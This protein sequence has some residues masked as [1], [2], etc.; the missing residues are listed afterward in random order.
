M[1][2][3]AG[4][5]RMAE[6]DDKF[7]VL[8]E[9]GRLVSSSL[10]LGEVLERVMDSLIRVTGAERGFVMLAE[11]GSGELRVEVARN[12]DHATIDSPLFAVSRNLVGEVVTQ[13]TPLLVRDALTDPGYQSFQSVVSLRLRSILCA[14]LQVRGQTIGAMYVDSRLR[15]GLFTQADLDLLVAFA[16]Q[17]AIAIENARLYRGLAQR[18]EEIAELQ[19][20]QANVFQS[21]ASGVVV[22]DAADRVTTFNAAAEAIFGVPADR[23]IGQLYPAALGPDMSQFLRAYRAGALPLDSHTGASRDVACEVPGRGRVYLSVRVTQLSGA[24]GRESGLVLAIE[25][26][27]EKRR[28][29]TRSCGT[30]RRRRS[31]RACGRRSRCCSPTSAATR[32]SARRRPPRKWW[33]CST[34]TWSWPRRRSTCARVRWTS[35]SATR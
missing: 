30:R 22:V 32:R 15:V 19:A 1:A 7:A 35:S 2:G 13:G 26:Q 5:T 9:V 3:A 4:S 28:C 24:G 17:A 25:D 27:T 6:R 21:V 14:P 16:N 23:A 31:S 11:P 18:L 8:Y 34:A 12:L 33:R 10:D 20:Y 29:A